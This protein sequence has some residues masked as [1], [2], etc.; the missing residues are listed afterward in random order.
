[1]GIWDAP[2]AV[3][4][5]VYVPAG[6][7]LGDGAVA[8]LLPQL[9]PNAEANRRK[10]TRNAVLGG[11]RWRVA[12]ISGRAKRPKR[13]MHTGEAKTKWSEVRP[14]TVVATVRDVVL[15]VN[16]AEAGASPGV[17]EGGLKLQDAPIGRP[18]QVKF[19]TA[20]V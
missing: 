12:S 16:V 10:R 11:K 6:V 20:V 7:P 13:A 18:E 19:E 3:T 9:T 2:V 5:M 4:V 15:I 17:T 8:E 14:G 1:M